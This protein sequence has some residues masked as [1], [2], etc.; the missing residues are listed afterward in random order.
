M[1]YLCVCVCLR[2]RKIKIVFYPYA[3]AHTRTIRGRVLRVYMLQY[4]HDARRPDKRV[5]KILKRTTANEECVS[6]KVEVH[7]DLF[8]QFRVALY[9]R[10]ETF[11]VA[12]GREWARDERTETP[13]VLCP[14]YAKLFGTHS[15]TRQYNISYVQL[16]IYAV[17]RV[18]IHRARDNTKTTSKC[19][20][21][22]F[23]TILCPQKRPVVS[24]SVYT[25]YIIFIM[26]H[27]YL[28]T[29]YTLR[30]GHYMYYI[31][32]VYVCCFGI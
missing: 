19:Y 11:T 22:T 23:P 29:T 10:A 26:Q 12:G 24:P 32:I 21:I 27:I 30:G 13:L 2:E 6:R 17:G 5:W 16:Y 8:S 18:R 7:S 4:T 3:H 31:I 28:Y 25:N 15:R 9:I 1:Q 14:D 20:R